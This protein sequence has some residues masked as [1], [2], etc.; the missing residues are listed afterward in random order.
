MKKILISILALAVTGGAY[1]QQVHDNDVVA[2][3]EVATTDEVPLEEAA[4]DDKMLE[5]VVEAEELIDE[6]KEELAEMVEE[7]LEPVKNDDGYD[8]R[9]DIPKRH[10]IN[11]SMGRQ[12]IDYPNLDVMKSTESSSIEFGSTFF[13]N[14]RKPILTPG[15][16][17]IRIGLDFSYLDISYASFKL[18]D[19]YGDDVKT[20]FGSIGMR[21]GPSVTIT[22]LRK[23]N[24]RLYGHYAP[25]FTA[26]TLDKKFEEVTYGYAGYLAG[27][28]QVSY[29]FLTLGIEM[30][31]TTAKMS[32]F[33][34]LNVDTPGLDDIWDGNEIT[35]PGVDFGFQKGPKSKVKLP[36][37]RFILGFRF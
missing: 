35:E 13:F 8:P 7:T 30:R 32:R 2:V 12:K 16:G 5:K 36:S 22:P 19:E 21:I 15:L 23:L 37:T 27:G 28:L 20:F 11:L 17:A 10:Y 14:G 34:G 26:Y 6:S 24:I 18:Q 29:M 25:S 33:D 3:E 4:A 1:A 31:G 9:T